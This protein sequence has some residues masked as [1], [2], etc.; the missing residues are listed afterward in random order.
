MVF[1]DVKVS[2][3][4]FQCGESLCLAFQRAYLHSRGGAEGFMILEGAEPQTSENRFYLN[5]SISSVIHV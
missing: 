3:I 1:L 4:S 2:T 5:V